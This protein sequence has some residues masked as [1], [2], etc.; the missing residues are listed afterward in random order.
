MR[1]IPEIDE[2][3]NGFIDAELTP[4]QHGEVERML[5][6]DPAV[7]ARLGELRRCRDLISFLPLEQAPPRTAE[8]VQVRLDAKS[9][10]RKEPL[11][12]DERRGARDLFVRRMLAIAAM[13]GLLAV[14]AAVVYTILSPGV[15]HPQAEEG[16][17]PAPIA[18]EDWKAKKDV[19]VTQPEPVVVK[20]QERLFSGR[21]ELRSSNTAAVDAFVRRAI[22]DAGLSGS[23]SPV[24]DEANTYV[25][26]CGREALGSL[27]TELESIWPRME[28]V[29]LLVDDQKSGSQIVVEDIQAEQVIE[30][31]SQSDGE[32]CIE[33]AK[34][35]AVLNRMAEL[36]PGREIAAVVE[37]R[38][39]DL[40]VI[41]KPVLTSAEKKVTGPA[42][43]ADEGQ[44]VT[45]TIIVVD[46]E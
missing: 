11:R 19:Q 10:L 31:I 42:S 38:E 18:D 1:E 43:R 9:Y 39:P 25:L 16:T 30:I 44:P 34:D 27:V 40:T 13:V 24:G 14:L 41:P 26:T 3:L 15:N 46:S 8:K 33:T 32:R 7:A 12:I 29:R 37:S 28:S 36:I 22:E 6:E 2:L 5:R 35:F 20:A 17:A 21:L 45:M 23:V 4:Q